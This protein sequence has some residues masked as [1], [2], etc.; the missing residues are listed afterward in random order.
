MVN[1]ALKY[2]PLE[3]EFPKNP[4]FLPSPL[5]YGSVSIAQMVNNGH[6]YDASA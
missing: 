1:A 2:E 6:R 4:L 3:V 5:R